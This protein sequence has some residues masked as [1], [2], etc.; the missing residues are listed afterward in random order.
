MWYNMSESQ[1][2]RAY[3]YITRLLIAHIW[4][5]NTNVNVSLSECVRA[6]ICDCVCVCTYIY[7]YTKIHTE[8]RAPKFGF[9]I[10][11]YTRTRTHTQV[12]W[13][14]EKEKQINNVDTMWHT[15]PLSSSSSTRDYCYYFI[16][17]LLHYCCWGTIWSHRICSFISSFFFHPI[18][19]LLSLSLALFF[20]SN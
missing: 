5:E 13:Y 12:R 17:V 4:G 11:Q 2:M 15:N 3:I 16:S 1:Y 19:S 14:F 9:V 7:L 10:H 6:C 18:F 8:M 20:A